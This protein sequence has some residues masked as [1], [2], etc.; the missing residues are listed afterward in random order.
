MNAL[1]CFPEGVCFI[2]IERRQ[3]EKP[4]VDTWQFFACEEE[5]REQILKNLS[6]KYKLNKSVCAIYLQASEYRLLV[7]EAPPVPDDELVAAVQWDVK[8]LLDAPIDAVTLDVFYVP[9]QSGQ[10]KHINVVA[11]KKSL[12]SE[13]VEILKHANINIRIIDIEELALRNIVS[14]LKQDQLGVVA[15][16]LRKNHGIVIFCKN[17][18]LYFSRR[19]DIGRESLR[20]NPQ[21]VE[22][23][24]LEIQRSIDYFDRH[25]SDVGMNSVVLMPATENSD[26]I[27]SFLDSN[28][29]LPCTMADLDEGIVWNVPRRG[30]KYQDY[31]LTLGT[32]LRQSQVSD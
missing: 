11:V 30:T 27:V 19:I 15:V 18:N 14:T 13:K 20:N 24:A 16:M 23:V 3:N 6:K 31:L 5:N 29:S 8:D 26:N 12:I 4:V 17:G 7:T 22:S 21:Q 2:Q 10:V 25:F 28:L 1:G 32:A 9:Q